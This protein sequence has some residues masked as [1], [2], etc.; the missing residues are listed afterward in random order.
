MT[1]GGPVGFSFSEAP[2]ESVATPPSLPSPPVSEEP[3]IPVNGIDPFVAPQV[4]EDE[5]VFTSDSAHQLNSAASMATE[6][7][8][9]AP[10]AVATDAPPDSGSELI[11]KDMTLI[12]R[13]RKKR[14]RLH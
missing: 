9:A 10:E 2:E 4:I 14:F 8:S 11:S 5:P 12:A 13:G 1:Q 3:T 7:L 6:I